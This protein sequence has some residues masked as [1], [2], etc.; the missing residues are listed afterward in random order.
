MEKTQCYSYDM[1]IEV[2]YFVRRSNYRL[3]SSPLTS[4]QEV[5][6]SD[7][8]SNLVSTPAAITNSSSMRD[9]SM[10]RLESVQQ[11]QVFTAKDGPKKPKWLNSSE[12]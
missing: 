3:S 2:T 12:K 5:L 10:P 1:E 6:V 8:G 4:I 7:I 11:I 9:Q